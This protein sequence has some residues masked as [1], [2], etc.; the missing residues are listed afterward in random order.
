M[1]AGD[2]K[3]A[4]LSI[5]LICVPAFTNTMVPGNIPNWLT[6]KKV[7]VFIRVRPIKRLI[8]KNGKTGIKRNVK[9]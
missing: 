1:R 7:R 6:Q 8:T 5:R 4:V 2:S 3:P 9:R